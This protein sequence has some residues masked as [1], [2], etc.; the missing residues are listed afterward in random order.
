MSFNKVFLVLFIS[1]FVTS[2]AFIPTTANQQPYYEKCDMI[3]KKLTLGASQQVAFNDCGGVND[4]IEECI[5]AAGILVPI[6]FIVSGSIVL[7]G[8]TLHWSEY[9]LSC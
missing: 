1:L 8:N 6:S 3:T 5:L 9:K 4:D 7:L 2:C